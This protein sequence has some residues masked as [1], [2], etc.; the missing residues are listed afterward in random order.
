MTEKF[1]V[2]SEGGTPT[3]EDR[4]SGSIQKRGCGFY[5]AIAACVAV[6]IAIGAFAI[7]HYYFHAKPFVP[8]ELSAEEQAVLD[9]KLEELAAEP[10]GVDRD[11]GKEFGEVREIPEG[12]DKEEFLEALSREHRTI[13]ITEKEINAMLNHNTNLEERVRILFFDGGI[14]GEAIVDVPQDFPMLGGTTIRART[15][16]STYVDLDGKLAIVI[17]DVSLNGI[18]LPNAWLGGVKGLNLVEQYENRD[19]FLRALADGI[20]EMEEMEVRDGELYIRLA[21]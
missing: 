11:R 12:L 9:A 10:Y 21:K 16:V 20:E 17:E 4:V 18:P 6:V 1:N 2:M 19:P 7:Y 14:G 13:V 8:I 5:G 15:A 3:L